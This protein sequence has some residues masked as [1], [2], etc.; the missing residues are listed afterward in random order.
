M[1]G[2]AIELLYPR[3]KPGARTQA[4]LAVQ[5]SWMPSDQ[6]TAEAGCCRVPLSTG[7]SAG[8]P[9]RSWSGRPD[10][11]WLPGATSAHRRGLNSMPCSYDGR[12]PASSRR[13]TG[14]NRMTMLRFRVL[15]SLR[16]EAGSIV[17]PVTSPRQRAVLA[18]LLLHANRTVS[19]AGLIDQVWGEGHPASAGGLVHT[20]IWQLRRLLA[21]HE[22]AA[23][24]PRITREPGGY[25]LR[26]AEG[27]LDAH[28]FEQLAMAG[29]D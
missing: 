21:A 6:M 9:Q 24:R 22:P 25:L 13:G 3:C 8:W 11:R 29:L 4:G 2:R 27:E 17:V 26:V 15:G 1:T 28:V 12:H 18:V 5:I 23:G 14:V 16:V 10:N 19:A 7:G 20:Y